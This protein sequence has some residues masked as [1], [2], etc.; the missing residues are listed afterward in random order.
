MLKRSFF[1][2]LGLLATATLMLEIVLTRIF[3]VI[4]WYHMSLVSV[5]MAMFGMTLGALIVHRRPE[6]FRPERAGRACA[7]YA[8]FFG[9]AIVVS[10]LVCLNTPFRVDASVRGA[11]LNGFFVIVYWNAVAAT[12][13]VFSGICV[14]TALTRFPAQVGRLYAADLAG[15]SVGCLAV[16]A[17]LDRMDAL[18]AVVLIAAVA[19]LAS[20]AFAVAAGERLGL[21]WRAAGLIGLAGLALVNCST[22]SIRIQYTLDRF[23]GNDV[24]RHSVWNA[25]SYVTV[26]RPI[27]GRHYHGAGSRSREAPDSPSSYLN[28]TMDTRASTAMV[29]FDGDWSHLDWL[30]YD[31]T[32]IV[33]QLR[34]DGPALAIGSGGGRDVLSAL[35][36]SRGQRRVVGIDINPVMIDLLTRLEAAFAGHLERLPDVVFHN[37][38]ARSWVTRS[39]DRFQVIAIPL[40]DTSAASAA[41]AYALTEN[42]LYTVEAIELFFDHLSDDGILSISRWWFHGV[43]GETHRLAGLAAAALRA[44]GVHDPRAYLTIVRGD[45]L[46]TL[47]MSRTPLTEEDRQKLRVAADRYG[48]E[49]LLSPTDGRPDLIAAVTDPDW[50]S[51]PAVRAANVA[52][53]TDDQPFFFH[54]YKIANLFSSLPDAAGTAQWDR[55]AM[56]ILGGLVVLVSVLVVGV[57]IVPLLYAR[58]QSALRLGL[59]EVQALV[60]FTAIGFAFMLFEAAQMQRLNIF[61]GYPIYALTVALFALLL[62]SSLGSVVA[63]RVFNRRG[64]ASLPWLLGCLL[65]VLIVIGIA[66]VPVM[67]QFEAASTPVRIAVAALLIAPAGFFMGM[68]FPLGLRLC[69]RATSVSLAWFWAVNGMAS[70]CAAVYGIALSISWG[71]TVTYWTSVACYLVAAAVGGALARATPAALAT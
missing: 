30:N 14:C 1:W 59:R 28:I 26:S 48:F 27:N 3:S 29:H 55:D 37:D 68:A 53:P 8:M 51:R 47:L 45:D 21:V 44:R 61:L 64:P 5:S 7:R 42:S 58:R 49:I 23:V 6:A 32:N 46:A 4:M 52:P 34:D 62:S 2:G 60:F 12:P 70:T 33:H 67:H 69:E 39:V 31:A 66:T 54:S 24:P 56:I 40:V 50:S 35:I 57:L 63:G 71:F 11:S 9:L 20:V 15:A 43:L 36:H 41:G 16:V 25:F 65:G 18:S 13:F 38:E 10:L 22:H 17:L 19:A